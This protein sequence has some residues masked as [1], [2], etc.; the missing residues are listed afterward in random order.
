MSGHN[1]TRH[2]DG[3]RQAQLASCTSHFVMAEGERQGLQQDERNPRK[4]LDRY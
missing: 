1:T 4:V 3:M 2:K